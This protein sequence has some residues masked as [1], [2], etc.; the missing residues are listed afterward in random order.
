PY[1]VLAR[2]VVRVVPEAW[3]PRGR[4]HGA[5]IPDP[6]LHPVGRQLRIDLRQDR[7]GLP[8]ALSRRGRDLEALR[9]VAGIA[10]GALVGRIGEIQIRGVRDVDL[11]LVALRA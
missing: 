5:R 9:F 2:T 10:A 7:S 6:G 4:L 8:G 3:H 1:R 11:L